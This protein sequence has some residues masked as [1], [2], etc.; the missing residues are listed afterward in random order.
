[1]SQIRPPISLPPPA[2]NPDIID[3]IV[4][5]RPQP[6]SHPRS[7][8]PRPSPMGTQVVELQSSEQQDEMTDEQE[9]TEGFD[10]AAALRASSSDSIIQSSP[11]SVFAQR[12]WRWIAIL[13]PRSM[14][15]RMITYIGSFFGSEPT[16]IEY[17]HAQIVE[18]T[19]IR[20]KA[21]WSPCP[22]LDETKK[23]LRIMVV[24]KN[25]EGEE[26]ATELVAR[27]KRVKEILRKSGVGYLAE[28]VHNKDI[29]KSMRKLKDAEE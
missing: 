16:V 20:I 17:S 5:R 19:S 25:G 11:L 1:M 21:E 3:R 6:A 18:K 29:F 15:D 4:H 10:A 9:D 14:V 27:P 2:M 26:H 12:F 7:R 13:S 8:R 22:S 28:D 23:V 24:F